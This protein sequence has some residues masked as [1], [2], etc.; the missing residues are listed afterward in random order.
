MVLSIR[1]T[2]QLFSFSSKYSERISQD[3]RGSKH[4]L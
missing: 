3:N 2:A 1:R 4:K